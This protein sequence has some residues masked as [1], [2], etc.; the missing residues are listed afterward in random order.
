VVLVRS[1][2]ALHLA[3]LAYVALG[4]FLAWR[5]PRA[6]LPHVA[7]VAWGIASIAFGVPCPLTRLE[8]TLRRAAGASPLDPGGFVDTYLEGVV[9]P[10]RYT[11]PVLAAAAALVLVSWIGT[12]LRHDRPHPADREGV[13]R[14]HVTFLALTLLAGALAGGAVAAPRAEAA[15]AR[16]VGN[17]ISWPQCPKGMGIPSRRS[18]GQPMPPASSKF[19]IIGLTNG[20]AFY[21]NPCL[22]S[23]VDFA[24]K[25]HLWTAGYA[26]TTYPTDAQ[27][28]KY[29]STG[30]YK[31]TDKL[32]KLRNAGY[33]QGLFNLANMAKAGLTSPMIWIDVE[34]YRVAPWSGSIAGNRAVV[35][36]V[37]NAYGRAG[38][39]TGFY[40]T[41]YL[42]RSIVGDLRY[43]RPE[44]RATGHTNQATAA[45]ACSGAAIQ[46]GRAVLGQWVHENRDWNVTCPGYAT[47]SVLK[48]H[49]HKY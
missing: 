31:G 12:R 21:P 4:G 37:V 1:V 2:A 23:Q 32:T 19:V 11:P 35:Q 49:F 7:A 46:G 22:K 9:Y 38:L 48:K 5:W 25:R 16:L 17:D 30:P 43:S 39:E 26:M 24:K 3:F 6:L 47:T 45:K 29:G 42:W 44:W 14:L 20:P 33:A 40:S 10:E 18:E 15:T 28:K 34:P 27:L 36:G 41:P 8:A 13:R